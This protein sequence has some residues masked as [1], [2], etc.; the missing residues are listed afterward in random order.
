[1]VEIENSVSGKQGT[2]RLLGL[3]LV[4]AVLAIA[5]FFRGAN[6]GSGSMRGLLR[7]LPRHR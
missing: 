5:A 6:P 7:M 1:M 4:P 3:L 2:P